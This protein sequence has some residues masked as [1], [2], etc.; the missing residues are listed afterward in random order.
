MEPTY[1]ETVAVMPS[2]SRVIQHDFPPEVARSFVGDNEAFMG[3]PRFA[4]KKKEAL[5]YKLWLY[6]A[7]R[8]ICDRGKQIEPMVGVFGN[9]PRIG[10]SF[11][12]RQKDR[13]HLAAN[14]GW[15]R[16]T[17]EF[18]PAPETHPLVQL[19][20][21]P[22]S[23]DTF[24]EIIDETLMHWKIHSEFYW[25]TPTNIFGVP[26]QW[27]V[28]PP[29]WV[30]EVW[31]KET[32]EL[33][34]YKIEPDGDSSRGQ[35]V[36]REM[37]AHAQA[38]NPLSKT[39]P[40]S[41]IDA[42]RLWITNSEAIEITRKKHF[43][44]GP[45]PSLIL[46]LMDAKYQN[47]DPDEL[48]EI[49]RRFISRTGGLYR[50]G[51]PVVIPHGMDIEKWTHTVQEMSYPQSA[52]QLRDCELALMGVPNVVAGIS[53]D[54]NRATADAAN[55]V[56]CEVTMNPLMAMIGQRATKMARKMDKRLTVWFPDCTPQNVEHELKEQ[57]A[58]FD[59]GA[60]TPDERRSHR[61]RRELAIP[62]SQTTYIRVGYNPLA[63]DMRPELDG[64]DPDQE[65]PDEVDEPD[66]ET[67]DE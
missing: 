29:A 24:S 56:F 17:D 21:E 63:V 3:S 53:K 46:K 25:W 65:D 18:T 47:P 54:Y 57:Q 62:E 44:N 12:T 5:H 10:Q 36:D 61:G 33:V 19:I 16:Q 31:N 23:V 60:L 52:E 8:R 26:Y 43:D 14:Y 35:F 7:I 66:E 45:N 28:V 2:P 67:D 6:V 37:M 59:M 41:A 58:D 34:G 9:N 48:D 32:K 4:L 55:F 20:E 64:T 13:D 11:V 1:L 42:G 27:W 15:V 39:Q 22:N 30:N 50:A 40:V 51:E 49:K 38:K